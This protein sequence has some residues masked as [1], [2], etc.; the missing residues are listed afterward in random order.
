MWVHNLTAS[1]LDQLQ[2]IRFDDSKCLC[3]MGELHVE[4]SSV[5]PAYDD[6]A[7]AAGID[8][9]SILALDGRPQADAV[10]KLE[11]GVGPSRL[12]RPAA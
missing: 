1:P 2:I 3:R 4:G 5:R 11:C 12:S 7:D 6:G 10:L 9:S 8:N